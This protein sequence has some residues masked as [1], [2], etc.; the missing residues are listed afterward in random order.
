MLRGWILGRSG[1][2]WGSFWTEWGIYW[3]TLGVRKSMQKKHG[4]KVTQRT[5]RR[6]VPAR[7]EG[8]PALRTNL[9]YVLR[10]D[11]RLEALHYRALRARWRI[12]YPSSSPVVKSLRQVPSS[13]SFVKS[14]RQVPSSSPYAKSLRQDASPSRLAQSPR[15]VASPSRLVQA[16]RQVASPGRIAKS[17]RQVT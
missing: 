6:P 17:P 3:V 9:R 10:L 13:S 4:K 5:P 16:P 1:G 7:A 8:P 2:R 12:I 14:L 15:Q 11:I